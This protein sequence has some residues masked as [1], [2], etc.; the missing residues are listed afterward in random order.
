MSRQDQSP[1]QLCWHYIP[2][3]V[4]REHFHVTSALLHS[5]SAARSSSANLAVT[6]SHFLA[7]NAYHP[8]DEAPTLNVNS[9]VRLSLTT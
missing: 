2:V 8:W 1:S 6:C 9:L 3:D 4:W 5:S 7:P